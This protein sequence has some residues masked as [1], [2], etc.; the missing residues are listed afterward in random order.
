AEPWRRLLPDAVA[1]H[2]ARH[3]ARGGVGGG[4]RLPRLVRRGG[5]GDLPRRAEYHDPPPADV[6]E[7]AL[8]DRPD[9]DGDLDAARPHP[10]RHPHRRRGR[11]PLLRR[12][13]RPGA[14]SRFPLPRRGGEG[15]VR[16]CTRPWNFWTGWRWSRGWPV[17]S[18]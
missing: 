3:P 10:D 16:G 12:R 6:G 4:L 9:A 17:P 2:A 14:W 7:R 15:R 8:R 13:A 11:P 1:R 18:A 5:A